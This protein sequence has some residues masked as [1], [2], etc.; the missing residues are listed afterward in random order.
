MKDQKIDAD[1]AMD[2]LKFLSH[3][4]RSLHDQRRKYEVQAFLTTLTFFAIVGAAPFLD[5]VCLPS[6]SLWFTIAVSLI[7][8]AVATISAKYLQEI[9]KSNQANKEV[10]ESAENEVRQLLSSS[11]CPVDAPSQSSREKWGRFGPPTLVWQSVMI[12]MFAIT[13]ALLLT[14][15][16]PVKD[17]SNRAARPAGKG[18]EIYSWRP[19]G[20]EWHFSL[21]P[22]T[23]RNKTL[24]EIKDPE[25]TVVGTKAIKDKLSRLAKGEFVVWANLTKEPFPREITSKITNDCNLLDINLHGPYQAD[26]DF[27]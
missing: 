17:E 22:G 14:C 5:K 23:N 25:F 4:H 27:Q 13:A 3:T 20:E 7:L 24:F 21:L 8:V 12:I 19:A 16:R 6:P 10:A 26:K 2:L 15:W 11:Q 18:I 9:H 1:Q